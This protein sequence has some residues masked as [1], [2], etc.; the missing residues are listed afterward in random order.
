MELN[1]ERVLSAIAKEFCQK[2][3][4]LDLLFKNESMNFLVVIFLNLDTDSFFSENIG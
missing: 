3:W 1:K 2:K 4:K